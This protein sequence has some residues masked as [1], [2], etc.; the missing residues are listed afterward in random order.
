MALNFNTVAAQQGWEFYSPIPVNSVEDFPAPVAGVITLAN[1]TTYQITGEVDI[2]TNRIV[3]GVRSG[4][5]GE[6]RV[7]DRIVSSTT[8]TM[9][10]AASGAVVA[11]F[12][13][14][15]LRCPNGTLVDISGASVSFVDCNFAS[16]LNGGTIALS[17]GFS[18]GLRTSSAVSGFTNSGF[19]FSGSTTSACRI[20][21]NLFTTNAGTLFAL[22]SAVFNTISLSRN[23]V[24]SGAGQTFLS[25][26]G[27]TNVTASGQLSDNAFFGAGTAVS[28]IANTDTPWT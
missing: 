11:F 16:V 6:N 2:G 17:G 28:G 4:I 20:W 3:F 23:T 12:Q 14:I 25:G 9:F 18:F 15:G 19:T 10:T 1:D 13:E 5:R 21:D 26:T 7:N 8:D 27:A 22:G 24:N